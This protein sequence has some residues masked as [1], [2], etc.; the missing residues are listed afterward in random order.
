[1][2]KRYFHSELKSKSLKCAV[3]EL[4]AAHDRDTAKDVYFK[5]K[6]FHDEY[7]FKQAIERKRKEFK[8]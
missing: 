5:W 3:A 7:D 6:V 2:K 8:K 4:D 1:M